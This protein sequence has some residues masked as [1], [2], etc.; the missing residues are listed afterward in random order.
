MFLKKLWKRVKISGYMYKFQDL[1][2]ISGHFRTTPRPATNPSTIG[3]PCHHHLLN[4]RWNQPTN[5]V[6]YR[7]NQSTNRWRVFLHYVADDVL[8]FTEPRWILV[9]W[10]QTNQDAGDIGVDAIR[11]TTTQSVILSKNAKNVTITVNKIAILKDRVAQNVT[12]HFLLIF[13]PC[14]SHTRAES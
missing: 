10:R 13:I 11:C 2:P 8:D 12:E 6:T 3:L 7:C 4:N 14:L 5:Y 9:G 1:T